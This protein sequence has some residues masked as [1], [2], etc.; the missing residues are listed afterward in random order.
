MRVNKPMFHEKIIRRVNVSCYQK[1]FYY[2]YY[3]VS[4]TIFKEDD[5]MMNMKN[6]GKLFIHLLLLVLVRRVRKVEVCVFRTLKRCVHK[7]RCSG[8]KGKFSA[9]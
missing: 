5:M 7:K 8:A 4:H 2:A 1:E 9:I 6:T 3:I